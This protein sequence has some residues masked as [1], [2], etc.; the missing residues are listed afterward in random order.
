ML[1][2]CIS[3][4]HFLHSCL[5]IFAE[6]FN[7]VRDLIGAHISI[8][9]SKTYTVCLFRG[10]QKL[11]LQKNCWQTLFKRQP[12]FA[13]VKFS[14]LSANKIVIVSKSVLTQTIPC[15]YVYPWILLSRRNFK[16]MWEGE[17]TCAVHCRQIKVGTVSVAAIILLLPHLFVN[18][19]TV[20]LISFK[21]FIFNNI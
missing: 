5:S 20:L 1:S 6:K 19:S 17:K 7:S 14:P 8:D 13:F 2:C 10:E 21:W 11:P 18:P 15:K 9:I 4:F 16:V 3:T 12:W